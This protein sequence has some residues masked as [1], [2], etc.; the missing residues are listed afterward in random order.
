MGAEPRGRAIR[1]GFVWA[2]GLAG[3]SRVDHQTSKD[4]PFAI[5]KWEVWQAYQRV[6]AN[7]GAPGVDGCSMEA[8]ETDLRGN[9]YKIWNRSVS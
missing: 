7:K 2:T 3:R 4:K 6:K 1:D 5:S 8:F 9:L